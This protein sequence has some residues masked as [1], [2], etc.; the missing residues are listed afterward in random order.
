MLHEFCVANC[1]RFYSCR[2]AADGTAADGN[3]FSLNNVDIIRTGVVAAVFIGRN[4]FPMSPPQGLS[5][6]SR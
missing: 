3:A 1:Y 5:T 6:I 4:N 2:Q